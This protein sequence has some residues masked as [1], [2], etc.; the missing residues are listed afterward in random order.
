MPHS[1][2]LH[3][4]LDP[5][6]YP[7]LDTLALQAGVHVSEKRTIRFPP[8][9]LVAVMRTVEIY[10]LVGRISIDYSQG[11]PGSITWEGAL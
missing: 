1:Q 5:C 10:G 9:Y 7:S 11:K 8:S 6:E 3:D 2:R 4:V